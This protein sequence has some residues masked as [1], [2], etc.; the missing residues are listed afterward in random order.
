VTADERPTLRVVPGLHVI[1]VGH[2]PVDLR[3]GHLVP[4]LPDTLRFYVSST[5][6]EH[7]CEEPLLEDGG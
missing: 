1:P 5:Q 3:Y 2:V 7:D 6:P 4:L